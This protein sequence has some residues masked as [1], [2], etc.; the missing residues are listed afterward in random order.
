MASAAE[1]RG[2]RK[3]AANL[4][5]EEWKL[6]N[7][8]NR[9]NIDWKRNEQGLRNMWGY[10]KRSNIYVIEYQEERERA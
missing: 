7:L 2:H 9:E 3:E 1:W 10:N 4:R 5:T 8:S 6:F